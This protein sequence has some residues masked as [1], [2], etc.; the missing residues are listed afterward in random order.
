MILNVT[1]LNCDTTITGFVVT[2]TG[3]SQCT[4]IKADRH[5]LGYDFL[6]FISVAHIR[7][8]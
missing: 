6:A 1:P 7:L 5:W 3:S 8:Q 2:V 4:L